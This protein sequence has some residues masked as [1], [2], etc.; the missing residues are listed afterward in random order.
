[1]TLRNAW[2]VGEGGKRILPVV[3]GE[4]GDTWIYGVG[5]DPIKV[6]NYRAVMRMRSQ[7]IWDGSCMPQVRADK[8]TKS[9]IYRAAEAGR[10]KWMRQL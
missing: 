7:C 10:R 4:I 2:D 5:S 6:R 8:P 1:M 9:C 3:T